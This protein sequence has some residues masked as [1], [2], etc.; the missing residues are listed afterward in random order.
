MTVR[1]K[2]CV[3]TGSRAEY[4]HLYWVMKGIEEDA[5]LELQLVITGMHLSPEFGL[6]YQEIEN[7]GFVISKKLETTMSSDTPPGIV[8][9]MGI[10]LIGF[11]DVFE[12]L[13]PDIVILLGDRFELLPVASAALIS[14]IPIGHIHGG[15][16]TAGA[17][18]EGI[19]HA[20]TKLAHLHFVSTEEYR[21]RVIQLGERPEYVFNFGAPC[22]DNVAN[23]EYLSRS[24]FEAFIG[25]KLMGKSLIVTYHPATLEASNPRDEFN[26]LLGAIDELEN[27][28]IIFTKTNADTN[29]RQIN[30]MIDSYVMENVEKSVSVFS[31]G[32]QA[33][34]SGLK[35]VDGVVGNSSSGVIEA[36]SF[37]IGTVNIGNRQEGRVRSSS[38]IDCRTDRGAILRALETLLFDPEYRKKTRNTENPYGSG[39]ASDKIVEILRNTSLKEI[40]KKKFYDL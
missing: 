34:L 2:I 3:V 40:V 15:E 17:F 23:T 11:A 22:I 5:A 9:S 12:E 28:S 24:Q 31:L 38:V 21:R 13:R 7:D 30:E 29:G 20:I 19:R 25:L 39:G 35:F 37:G 32:K 36:P 27:V 6:T 4:G 8:K 33:Y 18:D 16:I 10:G 1:R 26:E 14:K